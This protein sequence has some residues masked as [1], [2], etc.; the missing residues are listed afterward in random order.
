[1]KDLILKH[2]LIY[3]KTKIINLISLNVINVNSFKQNIKNY[4]KS[5]ISDSLYF[6]QLETYECT[7]CGNYC[8]FSLLPMIEIDLNNFSEEGAPKY[9]LIE[10][11]NENFNSNKQFN[12]QFNIIC[13]VCQNQ[14]NVKYKIINSSQTL[15]FIIIKL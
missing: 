2:V 15:R 8:N 6:S 3:N 1:M 14:A 7:K 11:I 9:D 10:Y 13:K 4:E 5:C 12:K